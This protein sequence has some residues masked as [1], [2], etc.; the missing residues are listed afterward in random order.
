MKKR[1]EVIRKV[2]DKQSK[3][4]EIELNKEVSI[5]FSRS[6]HETDNNDLKAVDRF[7]AYFK[8]EPNADA[9]IAILDVEGNTKVRILFI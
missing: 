1:L 5:P 9:Y 2:H 3:E 6:R 7:H 4:R 8:E